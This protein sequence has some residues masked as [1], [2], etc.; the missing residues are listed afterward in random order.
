MKN[1]ENKIEVMITM[2]NPK[3]DLKPPNPIKVISKQYES[4]RKKERRDGRKTDRQRI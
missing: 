2:E 4:E 3:N 1:N